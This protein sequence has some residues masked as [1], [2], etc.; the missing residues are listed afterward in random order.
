MRSGPILAVPRTFFLTATAKFR[1]ALPAG[2]LLQSETKIEPDLRLRKPRG[3]FRLLTS[4]F[5]LQ[6]SD[7]RLP[8]SDFRF[9]TSYIKLQTSDVTKCELRISDF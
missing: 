1:F 3:V 4:D 5:Q 2:M 8:T 6:T 7:L 9:K